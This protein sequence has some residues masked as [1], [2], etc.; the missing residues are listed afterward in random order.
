[1]HKRIADP[2][3][4][5]IGECGLDRRPDTPDLEIQKRIFHAQLDL[6]NQT[7]LPVII[8]CVKA[9]GLLLETLRS[10][11]PLTFGGM[12][13]GFAGPADMVSEFMTFNLFFSFGGLVTNEQA[14]KCRQAAK[15]VPADRL[16]VETDTPDHPPAGWENP[17]SEPVALPHVIGAL[18][19]LRNEQ[20]SKVVE[21]TVANARNLF[22]F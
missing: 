20:P 16:L 6:A 9:L 19:G 8:H 2:A 4:V 7:N 21:N 10:R 22:Q 17:L 18:A 14:N 12:L 13:H 1:M 5:A 3:T 15:I 11:G